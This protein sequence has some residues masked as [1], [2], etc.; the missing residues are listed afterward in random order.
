METVANRLFR[1][2]G[3][4]SKQGD[5]GVLLLLA[6]ND[7]KSRIEVGYGVE[8]YLTDA[9][10]G[11]I[12]R[13][14]RPDLGAGNYGAAIYGAVQAI[15]ARVAAGKGVAPPVASAAPVRKRATEH[16]Q[17]IPLPL[18]VLGAFVLFW[19]LG[20]GG[21]SGRGGG[22][23]G[24]LPGFMIG[25]LLGGGRGSGWGGGGGFGGWDSGGGGGGGF[26]GFGGGSSGGGGAS[27]GW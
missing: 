12:L 8:Q 5:N 24:F 22:G 11:T 17:G 20:R 10:S 1:H 9:T 14:I 2:F 18:I 25:T 19:L 21:R 15:A 23:G 7:R 16:R 26:G 27:S 6:V 13:S 3:V 4:G